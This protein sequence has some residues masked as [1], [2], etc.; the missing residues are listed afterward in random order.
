M[1][2]NGGCGTVLVLSGATTRADVERSTDQPDLIAASLWDFAA[3]F[4]RDP[5]RA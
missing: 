4:R 1:G 5:D 2:R 3:E